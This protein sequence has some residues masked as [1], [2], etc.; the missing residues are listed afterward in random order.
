MSATTTRVFVL[1]L[2]AA[3]GSDAIRSLRSL[4]KIALRRFGLRCL[5]IEELAESGAK[6]AERVPH[7]E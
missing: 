6:S 3:P 1:T 4:L 5:S 2:V 7:A